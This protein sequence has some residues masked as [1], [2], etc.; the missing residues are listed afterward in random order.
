[1]IVHSSDTKNDQG[2]VIVDC[3]LARTLELRLLLMNSCA[4][5]KRNPRLASAA[6]VVG[7]CSLLTTLII[8]IVSLVV[9]GSY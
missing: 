1:M 6:G 8:P 4:C 3:L 2:N 5:D 9:V 7:C